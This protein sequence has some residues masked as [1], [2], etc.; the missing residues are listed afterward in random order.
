MGKAILLRTIVLL[1][2]MMSLGIV[3]FAQGE[4]S[5]KEAR[6][7]EAATSVCTFKRQFSFQDACVSSYTIARNVGDQY[8]WWMLT[9]SGDVKSV[10]FGLASQDSLVPADYTGDNRYDIAVHRNTGAFYKLA[11][12]DNSFS[13]AGFGL[14]TDLKI[15]GGDFDGDGKADITVVRSAGGNFNWYSL[16]SSTSTLRAANFGTVSMITMPPGDYTGDGLADYVVLDASASP[17]KYWIQ[18]SSTGAVSSVGWGN[19]STDY[20]VTG[21]FLGDS[22][23]DF[24]VWRGFGSSQTGVW[25]ILENG[26]SSAVK[27]VQFGIPG[28]DRAV[29]GDFDGD[30]YSDVAVYR[31]STSTWYSLNSSNGAFKA[32]QW[33]LSTDTVVNNIGV[34]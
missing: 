22:K 6:E 9:P 11:S 14:A 31:P 26:G 7:A 30:S 3:I 13:A 24:A 2:A 29:R 32:V 18:N 5:S 17:T 12:E 16:N 25:W 4:D 34:R 8:Q 15:Q 33:G 23:L 21:D 19:Y 10:A 1:A 20:Y 27:A 28:S